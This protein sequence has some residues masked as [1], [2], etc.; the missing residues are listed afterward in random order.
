ME[1]SAEISPQNYCMYIETLGRA[2]HIPRHRPTPLHFW[3]YNTGS[4]SHRN[5]K[6]RGI[7]DWIQEIREIAEDVCQGVHAPRITDIRVLENS[8]R[9]DALTHT[10]E[11]QTTEWT[12]SKNRVSHSV[13]AV[14]STPEREVGYSG[15]SS[16]WKPDKASKSPHQS[17]VQAS[18]RII[19]EVFKRSFKREHFKSCLAWPY[20]CSLVLNFQTGTFIRASK[21]PRLYPYSGSYE[22]NL[23][24]LKLHKSASARRQ[25]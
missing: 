12:V 19:Y 4:V 3:E 1:I 17:Q 25:E 9:Q 18:R 5:P 23:E 6:Y 2:G 11:S 13:S 21:L 8:D 16:F 24:N 20:V 15:V 10:Q 14:K 22:V 7:T